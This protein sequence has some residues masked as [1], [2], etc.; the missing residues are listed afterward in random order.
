MLQHLLGR[1]DR[2][3][4]EGPERRT[5][6]LLASGLFLELGLERR[7]IAARHGGERTRDRLSSKTRVVLCESDNDQ[8][9]GVVAVDAGPELQGREWR[10]RTSGEPL[11]LG[12]KAVH[13]R[14][15]VLFENGRPGQVSWASGARCRDA[16]A[17]E[18]AR[19]LG[20][21]VERHEPHRRLAGHRRDRARHS[22]GADLA[23]QIQPDRGRVTGLKLL[24]CRFEDVQRPGEQPRVDRPNPTLRQ[25]SR[26]GR[27]EATE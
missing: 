4:D 13:C 22:G 14:R 18:T 5:P 23:I 1:V 8:L 25:E 24:V 16:T 7:T 2:H 17:L 12:A 11:V 21:R 15:R 27:R 19:Q 20:D 10:G 3:A 26:R 6:T 9:I